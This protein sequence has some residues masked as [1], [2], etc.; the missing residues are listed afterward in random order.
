MTDNMFTAHGTVVV[1]DEQRGTAL[2]RAK[3]GETY[4]VICSK[5]YVLSVNLR[6]QQVR[7]ALYPERHVESPFAALAS[8]GGL[9][10]TGAGR[11]FLE[12]DP[13]TNEFTY[14]SKNWPD[15]L[16]VGF[17]LAESSA[18][19]ILIA[20]HPTCRLSAYDPR[21]RE[22]TDYGRMDDREKYIGYIV[23][24]EKGWIY[25]GIGT[26]RRQMVAFNPKTGEKRQ[27]LSEPER[28]QGSGYFHKGRDGKIY[29]HVQDDLHPCK[30]KFEWKRFLD[31][32]GEPV[33]EAEVSP[34]AENY[35][36]YGYSWGVNSPGTNPGLIK[37]LNL[38]EHE[39]AYIHPETGIEISLRLEYFSYGTGL[40]RMVGGPDGKLYGC[41]AHPCHFYSFDPKA[42]R[43]ADYGKSFGRF[44]C[45][46]AVQ[47]PII[48][49]ACYTHGHIVHFDTGKPITQAPGPG[50]ERNPRVVGS[51]DEIYRP[52]SSASHPDGKRMVFGG[53]AGYGAV[54]GGLC[55]YNV[56][57]GEQTVIRNEELVPYQST[58]CMRFLKNGDLLCANTIET[59]GGAA[60]KTSEAEL[61]QFDLDKRSIVRRAVPVPG[62]REISVFEIDD[63]G[64]AHGITSDSIYSSASNAK[65]VGSGNA[66]YF[67]FD[68]GAWKTIHSRRLP[69]YGIP[70][71]GG[72][73]KGKN[74]MIY[75]IMTKAIYRID[76][77]RRAFEIIAAPPSD[78]GSGMAIMDGR[79]Y[80]GCGADLWSCRI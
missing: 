68:I 27:F 53:F 8:S 36:G 22:I 63:A 17:R 56:E 50:Q 54:G 78:I 65:F 69:E 25:M 79:L 40:A 3:D 41:S 77:G 31:G 24:D 32:K 70:I 26:E 64:L 13:V 46:Y 2:V 80:F 5:G 21:T 14:Y 23:E 20:S 48:G 4:F 74:G 60:P 62:A 52:R 49:G 76:P 71:L 44:I 12:Y 35:G 6:T 7:Q 38:D 16:N 43:I 15:E 19:L 34:L 61:F 18:G 1:S 66:V 72:M 30:G 57:T 67:V 37:K 10:Y 28:Q 11:M 55:V 47:G 58:V 29:G 73:L 33:P 45:T 75:G 9:F 51:H 59:P 42:G 39:L